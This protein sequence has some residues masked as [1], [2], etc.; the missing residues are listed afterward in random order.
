[1]TTIE[2]WQRDSFLLAMHNIAKALGVI[3]LVLALYPWLGGFEGKSR[4]TVKILR[5]DEGDPHQ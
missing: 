3:A 5:D 2:P 4:H 1:M